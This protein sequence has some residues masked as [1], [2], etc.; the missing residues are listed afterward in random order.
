MIAILVG[1]TASIVTLA[2]GTHF[3]ELGWASLLWAI[4]GAN[5]AGFVALLSTLTLE[6]QPWVRRFG[7]MNRGWKTWSV[8]WILSLGILYGIV[9][10]LRDKTTTQFLLLPLIASNGLMIPLFGIVQDGI[11]S[12][13]Q[14]KERRKS[15]SPSP[16][17]PGA[18]RSIPL[19]ARAAWNVISFTRVDQLSWSSTKSSNQE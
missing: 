7:L 1:L 5:I 11:V 4:L 19:F 18:A 13:I 10:M 15:S 17:G 2:L 9:P 3:L 12:R 8:F 16:G 6:R 14:R